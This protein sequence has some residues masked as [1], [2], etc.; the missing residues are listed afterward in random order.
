VIGGFSLAVS[1]SAWPQGLHGVLSKLLTKYLRV[2]IPCMV[3]LAALLLAS[4]LFRAFG[5]DL[6][7]VERVSLGQIIACMFFLQDVTGYGNITAGTW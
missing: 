5:L 7:L 2:G 1:V 6:G 4:Y 3:M